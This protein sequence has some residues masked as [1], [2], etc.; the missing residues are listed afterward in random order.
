MDAF[1][2]AVAEFLI[3][4]GLVLPGCAITTAGEDSLA[5]NRDRIVPQ[6]ENVS[7][8]RQSIGD[9]ETAADAVDSKFVPAV[10]RRFELHWDDRTDNTNETITIGAGEAIEVHSSDGN[11]AERDEVVDFRSDVQIQMP[12]ES[13]AAKADGATVTVRYRDGSKTVVESMTVKLSGHARWFCGEIGASADTLT[14]SVRPRRPAKVSD[15][16]QTDWTV[17]G[18]AR[19]SGKKFAAQ[20]DQVELARDF[21]EVE[22]SVRIKLQGNA[23]LKFANSRTHASQIEYWPSRHAVR[24]TNL[25]K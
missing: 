12:D 11:S 16:R 24:A 20:A 3:A 5:K 14:L 7:P 15:L 17:N 8:S 23:T 19:V 1:R 25:Q 18:Q 2:T 9:H 21:G 22:P 13:M 10:S 4:A 6:T